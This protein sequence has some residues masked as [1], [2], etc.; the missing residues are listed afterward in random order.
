MYVSPEDDFSREGRAFCA[1]SLLRLMRRIVRDYQFRGASAEYSLR[2][3]RNVLESEKQYILPFR[4]QADS[5]I[6][7]TLPY[8]LGVLG[9]FV[10]PLLLRLPEQVACRAQ[11]DE[12]LALLDSVESIPA[13]LVPEDSILREFIGSGA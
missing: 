11:V 10:R 2:L 1:P 6:T 7:T 8:E 5:H 12:V 13:A 4:A 3:W 9:T